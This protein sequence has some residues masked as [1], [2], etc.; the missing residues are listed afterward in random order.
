MCDGAIVLDGLDDCI[1]GY[2]QD[3]VLIYSYKRMVEHFI[4][5]DG[6][7]DEDAV[8]WIDYNVMGLLPNGR[9]FVIC[10]EF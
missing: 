6:M 5:S 7:L 9:G 8:E 2:S 3:G 10:F 1:L 4:N